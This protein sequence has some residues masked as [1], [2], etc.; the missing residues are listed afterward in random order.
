[1]MTTEPENFSVEDAQKL[2]EENFAS[3]AKNE[4][5]SVT[6]VETQPVAVE[7]TP[8][9]VEPEPVAA[10]PETPETPAEPAPAKPEKEAE[11]IEK[12]PEDLRARVQEALEGQKQAYQQWASNN[13]RINSM[14]K[15][16]LELK[17]ELAN[18]SP[19][20]TPAP[21]RPVP[22]TPEGWNTL[23]KDDP[24]LAK[25]V[26]ARIKAEV[27][28][29]VAP[30]MDSL[31]EV[32]KSGD[33]LYEHQHQQYVAEQREA[34]RAQ[35][36]NYE[37]VVNSDSFKHWITTIASPRTRDTAIN[38]IE[39]ADAVSVLREYAS[40]MIR[41]GYAKPPEAAA[42]ATPAATTQP[43]TAAPTA[44]DK[45]VEERDRKAGASTVVKNPP[46]MSARGPID[47]KGPVKMEDLET[48]FQE[49]WKK[50][51]KT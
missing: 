48:E 19:A 22:T 42:P 39:A 25:A 43:T 27:D 50:L 41:M 37:E 24:E 32:R 18:R 12:V 4:T 34:L 9:P 2:L 45:I 23:M 29:A 11:W 7:E 16:I 20:E 49:A 17:R 51:H 3:L 36:S 44:I 1:M 8:A 46:S 13:G 10:A 26:E 28:A 35:V 30:V 6:V 33:A 47:P 40:D 21:A 5:P 14:Q 31:Q 38:S 15:T